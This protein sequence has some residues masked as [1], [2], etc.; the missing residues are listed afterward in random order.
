MKNRAAACTKRH[1]RGPTGPS[2]SYAMRWIAWG[3]RWVNYKV[4]RN[5]VSPSWSLVL[6]LL[7]TLSP[8]LPSPSCFCKGSERPT[9]IQ[10]FGPRY[11]TPSA[12]LLYCEIYSVLFVPPLGLLSSPLSPVSLLFVQYL[13]LLP[14]HVRF[15]CTFFRGGSR[16]TLLH[17]ALKSWCVRKMSFIAVREEPLTPLCVVVCLLMEQIVHKMKEANLLFGGFVQDFF[18][19]DLVSCTL[20]TKSSWYIKAIKRFC[21]N[22]HVN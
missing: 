11:D 21:L 14:L 1:S 10:H 16:R 5:T 7:L 13:F 22:I 9:S 19:V 18:T 15:F 4:R 3:P 17:S 6:L 20:K 12:W 8:I 2:L